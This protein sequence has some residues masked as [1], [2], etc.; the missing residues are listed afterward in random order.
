MKL[1]PLRQRRSIVRDFRLGVSTIGIARKYE[2]TIEM[3]EAVI[4]LAMFE[5][6]A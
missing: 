6:K 3:I 4:R 1:P 2:T 5:V